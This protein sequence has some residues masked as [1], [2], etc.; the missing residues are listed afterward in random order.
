MILIIV[1]L[2]ASFVIAEKF[3]DCLE[4][5]CSGLK[6]IVQKGEADASLFFIHLH[7]LGPIIDN[8]LSISKI[9]SDSYT[10]LSSIVGDTKS[11]NMDI[12]ESLTIID[13]EVLILQILFGW[14]LFCCFS[15]ISESNA[16]LTWRHLIL[17]C[18][19]PIRSSERLKMASICFSISLFWLHCM[20]GNLISTDLVA[21]PPPLLIDKL[22][23][24]FDFNRKPIF[25]IESGLK[26]STSQ[27]HIWRKLWNKKI[28]VLKGPD[29]LHLVLNDM[30]MNGNVLV[31]MNYVAS[32]VERIYCMQNPAKNMFFRG[33]L[34]IGRV[35]E[36]QI[37][38]VN[39][40]SHLRD[41]INRAHVATKLYGIKDK[42]DEDYAE[43]VLGKS[44][45][46]DHCLATNGYKLNRMI[47]V[48]PI[49][50]YNVRY[51]AT[52]M[53]FVLIFGTLCVGYEFVT[54]H[55]RKVIKSSRMVS[56]KAQ[57]TMIRLIIRLI[58]TVTKSEVNDQ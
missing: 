48:K 20:F 51:L 8:R 42:I 11:R 43:M 10:T 13:V 14:L 36:A 35:N 28:R 34:K 2:S 5:Q 21:A 18:H 3:G 22:T 56:K 40:S 37:L 30:S 38:N 39:I 41:T 17:Q 24:I 25:G 33:S 44:A 50:F 58:I 49:D 15:N 57:K 26:F 23:D 55:R 6:G 19:Q 32:T 27:D 53:P 54:R 47:S 12:I 29:E 7:N 4:Y 31:S 1:T 52:T 16:W 9:N 45:K 46:V